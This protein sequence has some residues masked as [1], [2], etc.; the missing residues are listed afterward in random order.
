MGSNK[1]EVYD[2]IR[3]LAKKNNKN[4]IKKNFTYDEIKAFFNSLS[5]SYNLASPTTCP[6]WVL[7][8]HTIYR[9]L[10]ASQC[11]NSSTPK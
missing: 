1:Q 10:S 6:R 2:K 4:D 11:K 8:V 9:E 3:E 7:V 5:V